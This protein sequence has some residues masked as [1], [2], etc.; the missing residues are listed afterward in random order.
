MSVGA[1][2]DEINSTFS[3]FVLLELLELLLPLSELLLVF[4]F[5]PDRVATIGR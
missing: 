2:D 4:V 5:F 3:L 1:C